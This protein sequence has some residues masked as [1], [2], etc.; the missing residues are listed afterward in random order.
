MCEAL[1]RKS[2]SRQRE[3][4]I[5]V[6]F[7]ADSSHVKARTSYRFAWTRSGCTPFPREAKLHRDAMASGRSALLLT[8]TRILA[9]AAG[10][11]VQ[12]LLPLAPHLFQLSRTRKYASVNASIN[13]SIA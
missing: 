10:R 8:N 13:L 3:V 6:L 5:T 11:T 4:P 7:S 9:F 2:T 1:T 12:G